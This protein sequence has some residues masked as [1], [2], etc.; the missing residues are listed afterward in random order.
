[1]PRTR[2]PQPA[3]YPPGRKRHISPHVDDCKLGHASPEVLQ[4]Q[5]AKY[6]ITDGEKFVGPVR[7][8]HVSCKI[9]T[10]DCGAEARTSDKPAERG[11]GGFVVGGVEA[12]SKHF[13]DYLFLLD[14]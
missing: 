3:Q 13:H 14:T 1:M 10:W 12:G 6:E 2:S 7:G 11:F 8:V 9:H 5:P 4:A